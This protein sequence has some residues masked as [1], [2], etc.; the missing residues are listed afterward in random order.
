MPY[1]HKRIACTHHL[2]TYIAFLKSTHVRMHRFHVTRAWYT[3]TLRTLHTR[4]HACMHACV[5]WMHTRTH[6]YIYI[7]IYIYMCM[8][9]F[10][11]RRANMRICIHALNACMHTRMHRMRATIHASKYD[12]PYH[13]TS[14]SVTLPS[15][16]EVDAYIA[17]IH[18]IRTCVGI[19]YMQYF[20]I[21]PNAVQYIT[22]RDT[23]TARTLRT[24]THPPVHVNTKNVH[25]MPRCVEWHYTEFQHI[26]KRTHTCVKRII[27][28]ETYTNT[29]RTCMRC[30]ALNHVTLHICGT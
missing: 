19:P 4:L 9:V 6:I 15:I 20:T 24:I 30:I 27:V 16:T 17:F 29:L 2:H 1:N 12:T 7:Y 8:C 25:C 21:G 10:A 5:A 3:Y 11:D 14:H 26:R 23:T 13:I 28:P 22:S 18:C